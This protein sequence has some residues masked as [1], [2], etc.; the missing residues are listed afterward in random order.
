MAGQNGSGHK[1]L[2]QTRGVIFRRTKLDKIERYHRS[3]KNIVKLE[4]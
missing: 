4:N 1:V 3:M 2:E